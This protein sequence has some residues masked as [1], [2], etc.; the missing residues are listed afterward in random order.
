MHKILTK[1]FI[2]NY[3]REKSNGICSVID[4]DF[5]ATS[6]IVKLKCSCGNIFESNY[7]KLTDR[8]SIRCKNCVNNEAR[9]RYSLPFDEVLKRIDDSGCKYISGEYENSK[10]KLLLECP[11][12]NTFTKSLS[13]LMRGQNRC[14]SCANNRIAEIKTRYTL[15][16][17]KSFLG[18]YGITI[19]NENEYKNSSSI[20]KCECQNGHIF[21]TKLI[22]HLYKSNPVIC[23]KCAIIKNSKENNYNYNGGINALNEYCRRF[24]K[25][26]RLSIIEKYNGKCYLTKSNKDC[27]VHHL[28]SLDIIVKQ[29]CNELS[30]PI[31][32]DINKYNT[33][34]LDRIKNLVIEKHTANIGIVLQRK[35]HSKFHALYGKKDNT[36]EQFNDF[37]KKYY[38]QS[39]L[40]SCI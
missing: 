2:S 25:S 18:R 20:I 23:E 12:G 16:I 40:V 14:N 26:W 15:D 5:N 24:L 17:A 37:I 19:L 3:V 32:S 13:H 1:D 31:L 39:K 27:E 34:D 11:C 35:V 10:S 30:L 28:I 9:N 29:C 36:I 4:I 38:P 22:Y 6:P 8:K 21:T 33:D 7:K